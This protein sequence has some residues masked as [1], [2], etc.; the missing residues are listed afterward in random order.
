MIASGPA[1]G[2]DAIV[3]VQVE[4]KLSGLPAPIF[5]LAGTDWENVS[6]TLAG[7]EPVPAVA[8]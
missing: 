8:L 7:P 3:N 5:W 2:P 1:Q 4:L 6:V